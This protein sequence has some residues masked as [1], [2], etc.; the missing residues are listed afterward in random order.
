[1]NAGT[2]LLVGGG[3]YG[4]WYLSQLGLATA[5]VQVVF[6][7]I[8]VVALTKLKVRLRIQNIS[9][10]AIRVNSMTGN[11]F[12]DSYDQPLGAISYFDKLEIPANGEAALNVD[13]SLSLLDL[14]S[15]IAN[16]IE[17][18]G[19]PVTFHVVGNVNVNGLILPF[20]LEKMLAI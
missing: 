19:T 14:P 12:L 18:G 15:N 4:I 2:I 7:G 10:V 1:M 6:D 16:L 13:L 9:N 3:L 5:T 20:T 8:S 11:V 17:S